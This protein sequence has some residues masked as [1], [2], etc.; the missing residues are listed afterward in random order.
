M[1]IDDTNALL[2]LSQV[3][4]LGPIRLRK[5]IEKWG[6]PSEIIKASPSK[7]NMGKQAP[8]RSD[9]H[10]FERRAI[11]QLEWCAKMN[12]RIVS[13]LDKDYP[14]RLSYF[15]DTPLQLLVRGNLSE[16]N[17]TVAIVGTRNATS[18]GREMV[19]SILDGLAELNCC[20]I[21]GLALGI[22]ALAHRGAL[23]RNMSTWA[24]LAHGH[25][26]V[27][28]SVH[29]E[30]LHDIEAIGCSISEY[31]PF[32]KAE[33][34]F[35]PARNRVIA[36]LSDVVLVVESASKG[37]ALV[38][39]Q[40]AND[41]NKEVVAIPGRV[42]D[43][44]SAGCNQLIVQ[45][46]ASVF[47]NSEKLTELMGWQKPAEVQYQ[48]PLLT[49]AETKMFQLILKESELHID[50]LRL[51]YGESDFYAVML[52]LELKEIVKWKSGN[53]VCLN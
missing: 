42:G 6:S 13:Y 34:D 10:L 31:M 35:F 38:T 26:E 22:D 27:Y 11:T 53:R 17:R 39:A 33:R 1:N 2:V 15:D 7:W 32:V 5:L 30:L 37:G 28:P 19:N 46:K 49:A 51:L 41:Y 43:E 21:S 18:Y 12:V 24:C 40:F 4:H 47:I 20:I 9:L 36:A 48:I 25:E 45:N 14:R 16:L 29:R 44:F 8:S 52:Q 3:K 50:E 23:D